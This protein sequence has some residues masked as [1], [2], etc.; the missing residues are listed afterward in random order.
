MF[1]LVSREA[2]DAF[3]HCLT[4]SCTCRKESREVHTS[5][6]PPTTALLRRHL[7][8]QAHSDSCAKRDREVAFSGNSLAITPRLIRTIFTLRALTS[9]HRA[10]CSSL[11]FLDSFYSPFPTPLLQPSSHLFKGLLIF[12]NSTE[13]P[14]YLSYTHQ[15]LSAV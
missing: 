5:T 2:C 8:L 3:N 9:H 4:C 10:R 12:I 1:H 7:K 15:E 11:L 14:N 13:I 6:M